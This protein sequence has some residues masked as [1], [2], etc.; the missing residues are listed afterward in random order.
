M[1]INIGI[2][3]FG[4]IGRLVMRAAA[5]K[6]NINIVAV[7]DPFIPVDYMEY[8]YKYDTVHGRAPEKEISHCAESKSLLLDGKAVKVFG[9]MD[10]SNIQ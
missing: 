6:P 2:N 3:G 1:S 5:N 7:N 4:R 9:E 10:P 8:M